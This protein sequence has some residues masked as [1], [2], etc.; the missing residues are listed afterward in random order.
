MHTVPQFLLLIFLPPPRD[1]SGFASLR[2]LPDAGQ[3]RPHPDRLR[4]VKLGVASTRAW[5]WPGGRS[6]AARPL[7]LERED[8]V[9]SMYT[10]G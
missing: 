6:I 9:G 3:R 2:Y 7:D 8:R 1:F 4:R 5:A 10:W